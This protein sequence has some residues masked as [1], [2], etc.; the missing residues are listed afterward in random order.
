VDDQTLEAVAALRD[1]LRNG[2]AETLSEHITEREIA[3]LLARTVALLDDPIMPSPD[4]RRP[5]PWPAF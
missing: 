5:I 1:R 3:A 2:L 4:R